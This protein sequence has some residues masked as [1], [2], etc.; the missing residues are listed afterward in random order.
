MPQGSTLLQLLRGLNKA[1]L[2]AVAERCNWCR[3]RK[4][5]VPV[6]DLSKRVRESIDSNV[7]KGNITFSEAM[8]D[9]RDEVLIPGPDSVAGKIREHLRNVPTAAHIGEVRIE[10]EWFSAQIYGALWAS[11][12]R[13]YSVHLEYQLNSRSRPT[14]DLYVKS[15]RNEGDYLIEVKLAPI[16]NGE[17]V[18]RQ[19]KK[20]HRAIENDLGRSRERTFLCII[21]EDTEIDTYDES[22]KSKP[23]SEYV[24]GVPSTVDEIEG[25]IPRTEVVSNTIF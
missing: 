4:T 2:Q 5:D 22:R 12:E 24:D 23:L 19:L 13:P 15:D 8:Q 1:E 14:A 9:I 11:I 21:G 18:K 7:D 16:K 20:Y 10:E 3:V 25:E 6:R 17:K